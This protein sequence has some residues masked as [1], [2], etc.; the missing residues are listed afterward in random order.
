MEMFDQ[1]VEDK[2]RSAMQAG[3][4]DNLKGKGKPLA[5]DDNPFEPEE[6]RLC[7]HILRQNDCTYGWMETGQ[8]IDRVIETM[9]HSFMSLWQQ[10]LSPEQQT[11]FFQ[12][13]FGR[14]RSINR[15]IMDYNLQVPAPAFQKATLDPRLEFEKI[16]GY[17]KTG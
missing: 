12:A 10:N 5:L 14:T 1:L 2:I 11:D 13:L 3:L 7:N 15:C 17:T 4:F 16:R 9:R 8:E 6:I